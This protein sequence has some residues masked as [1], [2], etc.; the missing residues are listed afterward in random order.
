M[1]V[2]TLLL[3][4]LAHERVMR[5]TA[6]LG[7]GYG[8]IFVGHRF[9]DAERGT[10]GHDPAILRQH[11]ELLRRHRFNLVPLA[12]L[13][14]RLREHEPLDRRT[15]AFTM[16]D[17][18]A[19][20]GRVAAPI[21]EAYDCPVTLF[22]TTGFV[23]GDVWMWWDQIT[24]VLLE[25]PHSSLSLDASGLRL[26]ERW[27]STPDRIAAAERIAEALKSVPDDAKWAT[28]EAVGAALGVPIPRTPPTEYAPMTWDEIRACERG[29]TT[30]GPHTVTHPILTRIDAARAASEIGGAWTR[31]TQ[32]LSAPIPIFCYPNGTADTFSE[33]DATIARDVGLHAAVTTEPRYVR[34]TTHGGDDGALLYH[35]PRF[36]YP[37]PGD[38]RE[39]E[40]QFRHVVGGVEHGKAW[41]RRMRDAAWR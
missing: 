7:R 16:D 24:H 35:I 4:A 11:L 2:R 22:V 39:N 36:G 26:R 40:R 17:G 37:E 32:M 33:R 21:F 5:V 27:S 19:D 25:T 31:L 12:E 18:Y 34:S 15:V 38:V 30:I 1:P 3:E 10:S 20:F 8:T 14:R 13:V 6:A 29:V 9:A 28:I 23:D 41:L